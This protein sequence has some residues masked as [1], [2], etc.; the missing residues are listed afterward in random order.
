MDWEKGGQFFFAFP[1]DQNF[2]INFSLSVCYPSAGDG[3]SA[4][5]EMEVHYCEEI[6]HNVK[7]ETY[8][9]FVDGQNY[10]YS[11]ISFMKI[12]L[13]NESVSDVSL[14][15]FI[16][17]YHSGGQV[18]DW[19]ASISLGKSHFNITIEWPNKCLD[20]NYTFPTFYHITARMCCEMYSGKLDC[21]DDS[22]KIDLLQYTNRWR[23]TFDPYVYEL[24]YSFK[25]DYKRI[26]YV[27]AV[28]VVIDSNKE[29]IGE[30]ELN[31]GVPPQSERARFQGRAELGSARTFP[32]T[33]MKQVAETYTSGTSTIVYGEAPACSFLAC[34][35]PA[36]FGAIL[37]GCLCCVTAAYLQHTLQVNSESVMLRRTL[38]SIKCNLTRD[39]TLKMDGC[40]VSE[41]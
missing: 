1:F 12:Q 16:C 33:K 24:H 18:P 19:N 34:I 26:V 25:V 17:V 23:S 31:F 14:Y 37:I 35:L 4:N 39:T 8:N 3:E 30:K 9:V 21:L 40:Q 29:I 27:N 28:I 38:C 10:D 41:G 36:C 6:Y 13:G 15:E 5:K 32:G 20:A 2:P 22:D 11:A 7:I